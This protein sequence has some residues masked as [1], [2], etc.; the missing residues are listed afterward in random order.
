MLTTYHPVLGEEAILVDDAGA[1]FPPGRHRSADPLVADLANAIEAATGVRVATN[2]T[3]NDSGGN[4]QTEFDILGP[5]FVIE[6]TVSPASLDKGI[7]LVRRI[8]PHAAARDIIRIAVFAPF[9][10]ADWAAMVERSGFPVFRRHEQVSSWI[11]AWRQ[12][13]PS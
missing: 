7:Q 3:V 1:S 6:V 5:D 8:R 4:M 12:E 10:R 2:V 13:K 11:G 9:A